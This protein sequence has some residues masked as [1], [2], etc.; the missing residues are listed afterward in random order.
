[1]FPAT[2]SSFN[3]KIVLFPE[4]KKKFLF[5]LL[6]YAKE[7]IKSPFWLLHYYYLGVL[8]N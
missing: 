2:F 8:K 6:K 1:M 7:K 3:T 5:S 4:Q